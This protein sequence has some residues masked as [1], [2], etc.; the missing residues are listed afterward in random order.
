MSLMRKTSRP[1]LR[2]VSSPDQRISSPESDWRTN[3]RLRPGPS[4]VDGPGGLEP[5]FA[6][7]TESIKV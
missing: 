1:V 3:A 2:K 7:A 5:W 4:K 6:T